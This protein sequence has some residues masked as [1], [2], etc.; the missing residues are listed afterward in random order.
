M[1]KHT[2]VDYRKM[3]KAA[4]R[5]GLEVRNGKGDHARFVAP[6]GSSMTYCRREMGTGLACKIIKWLVVRGVV[7]SFAIWIIAQVAG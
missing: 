3:E 2:N 7:L 1:T 4:L 5:A 6:D